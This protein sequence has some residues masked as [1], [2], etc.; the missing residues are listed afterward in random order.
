[1]HHHLPVLKKLAHF[2]VSRT[3]MLDPHRGVGE[4]QFCGARRRG[5][6]FTLGMVPP[7]EASLRA[8]SRSMSALRA[9]RINVV[10]SDT[11][12]NSWALRSKSSSSARVVLMSELQ[13]LIIASNDDELRALHIE[14]WGLL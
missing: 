4:N 10:F 8:L 2:P 12:V 5:I 6:F 3:E 1:M 13:A 14:L 7:R 11:P 9:S